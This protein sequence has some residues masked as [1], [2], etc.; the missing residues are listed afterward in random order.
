[1]NRKQSIILFAGALTLAGVLQAGAF[2]SKNAFTGLEPKAQTDQTFPERD[3]IHQSY[4]LLPGARVEVS[5]I[6]G[7]VDIETSDTNMAEVNIIRSARS[8]EDLS[9]R[10]IDIEH[11][12]TGLVIRG[13]RDRSEGPATVRHRVLLKIPRRVELSVQTINAR[14]NVGEINGPVRLSRINGAVKVAQAVAYAEASNI[15]GSLTMTIA[16]LSN[17]G[18]RA[19]DINGGIELRF[20]DELNADLLITEFNGAVTPDVAN[21]SVLEKTARTIFRARI[22]AGGIPISINDVNGSVRLKRAG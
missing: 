14:V 20:A 16:G 15:N 6:Y 22:G 4:Q 21:V 17:K 19:D 5:V 3:E 11:T 9:S 13:E 1:M 7:L 18:I 10:K 12:P 2:A 8:R